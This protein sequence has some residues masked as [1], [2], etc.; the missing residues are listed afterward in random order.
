MPVYRNHRIAHLH[1]PKTAGTTLETQ[2]AELGDMHWNT[3]SWYGSI[4]RADRWYED[5]HLSLNELRQL[6]AG[7]I[8]GMDTFAVV[9]NPYQRLIS[10]YHWR[11]ALVFGQNAPDLT[12][13]ESFDALIAAIPLDLPYNWSRY[14]S[15]ADRDHA[16]VLIHLRPQW[17]YVCGAPGQLDP[18]VEIVR[19]ERL[20]DDLEPLYRRWSV[21]TRPFRQPPQPRALADYYTDAS[22]AVVNEVYGRDLEWFGYERIDTISK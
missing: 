7:D 10:E 15:L 16:N 9:R 4:K 21:P 17:Q 18:T 22:L 5:H 6:S 19:F 11:H 1:I 2:F 14:V 20:R 12:A 13:F 8:T 3:R